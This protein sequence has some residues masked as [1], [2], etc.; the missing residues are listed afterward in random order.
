MY[1]PISIFSIDDNTYAPEGACI[2][3][4]TQ[5]GTGAIVGLAEAQ[6]TIKKD[7]KDYIQNKTYQSNYQSFE[8]LNKKKVFVY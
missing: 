4:G 1:T 3:V 5:E 8:Y 7:H 2:G 6:T